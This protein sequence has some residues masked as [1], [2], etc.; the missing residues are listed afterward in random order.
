MR[1]SFADERV[2]A[3]VAHPD[4]AELLC[5]GTL[6]RAARDGAAIGICVLCLGDK[7]QPAQPVPDLAMVRRGEMQK[8]AALLGAELFLG[9]AP[10]SELR[11]DTESRQRLVTRLRQFRPTLLLAHSSEDYH[12]DHRTASALSE[13]CSWLAAS[14]GYPCELPALPQQ[15]AVWWM[16]TVGMH[17]FEPGFYV[18]VS[19][20]V[21]LKEQMLTCH[22][23]QMA[24]GSDG[25]FSPLSDL[26]HDQLAARGRQ[27][28]CVAAEAFQIHRAFRRARAW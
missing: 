1:L 10:D 22:T 11:D 27:S 4:D 23:S 14:N 15:P 20:F 12:T 18:D 24:R 21:A 16:D 25:D 6:A 7:G 9:F 5:A 2:L 17:R 26:M 28:D 3:I 19:D 13:T 8:A